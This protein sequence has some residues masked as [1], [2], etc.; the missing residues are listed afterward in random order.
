MLSNRTY[1]VC[2]RTY[3]VCNRNSY[4]VNWFSRWKQL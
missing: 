1:F 3:F 4:L 2:N